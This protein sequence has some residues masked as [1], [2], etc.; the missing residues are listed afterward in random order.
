MKYYLIGIKG[1]GMS[2]LAQIL[3]DL[4]NEVSGYDDAKDFKFT[5][6]GLDSRGIKIHY[7]PVDIEPDTIVSR[8]VAISDDHDEIK[9]VRELGFDIKRYDE[10]I[11]ELTKQF[12]TIGISGTHG[13][14]TTSSLI[15]H[16]LNTKY[17]TNYFVGAGDGYAKKE[18]DIFI[19]ES[20]EFN[21]HFTS[22]H[23]NYS[24]IT[25]IE[26]EHMECYKD[27][28]DIKNTF[29]QF[30][31]NT[32][33]LVIACGDEEVVRKIDY[34][35]P[36]L[37]YGFNDDN[38]VVIKN[39]I[40]SESG[41]I[42]DLYI[43]DEL[44][45]NFD[46]PLFGEYM[47]LNITAAILICKEQ[48]MLKEGIEEALKTFQNAKRRF[49]TTVVNDTVIID[50]YA[51]HPT[52]IKVTLEAIKQRYPNKR[53]VVVFKPNTYS[54][55]KDFTQDFATSLSIADKVYITP[56]EANRE[57]Q[58]DYPNVT[59]SLILDKI[60][61]SELI[62]E[63]TIEILSKEKD[64]VVSFMSC[65]YVDKLIDGFKKTL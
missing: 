47:I 63:E 44:Y 18:N 37:F 65:A 28:E 42:F 48:G 14:T 51:H 49:E 41:S 43:N 58:S 15:R 8:T 7:T 1:T 24:V 11:G 46:V 26:E 25:N 31:N 61:G 30:A 10:I 20:D 27:I 22:Y 54:R 32:K 9:R 57:K 33:K 55:T 6:K 17:D 35:T 21:R 62:T 53:H 60:P 52:E 2:T 4:G 34:K 3:H 50:D 5:Q 36:V 16:I 39:L 19:L 56:I 64:S 40:L 13:K 38:D 45:G 23:P 59:S 12:N 29:E